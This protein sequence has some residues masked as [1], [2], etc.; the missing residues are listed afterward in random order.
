MP[1]LKVFG[2]SDGQCHELQVDL[3][4]VFNQKFGTQQHMTVGYTGNVNWNLP[5]AVSNFQVDS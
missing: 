2:V 5:S 4:S 3:S 1:G